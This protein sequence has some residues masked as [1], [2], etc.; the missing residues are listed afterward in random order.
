MRPVARSTRCRFARPRSARVTNSRLRRPGARRSRPR[1]RPRRT[2]VSGEAGQHVEVERGG[3]VPGRA[4]GDVGHEEVGLVVGARRLDVH[5]AAEGDAAAVRRGRGGADGA[6]DAGQQRG[7]P[8]V[9]RH[10][11]QVLVRRLVIRLAHA[12]GGE[13]D[14]RP[15]GG[16][17]GLV[18][19]EAAGG[20]LARRRRR[21]AGRGHLHRPHVRGP[22]GVDITAAVRAVDGAGDHADVALPL[23]LGA[24]PREVGRAGRARERDPAPARRPRR[25]GGA[26]GEV[27]DRARLAAGAVDEVDL[28]R[29]GLAVRLA[30]AQEGEPPAVRR[31]AGRRVPRPGGERRAGA[32]PSAGTIHSAES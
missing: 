3:Q 10:R 28:R 16:E 14:P 24:R 26:L 8:A 23:A 30:R 12:R 4:A 11:E 9:G 18:L 27:G 13:E 5:D 22:R 31:P 17:H 32:D 19:V 25:R 21:L 15:V 7:D 29:L 20:H 2:L 1:R 6:V